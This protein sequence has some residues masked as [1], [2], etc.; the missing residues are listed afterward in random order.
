MER[1]KIDVLTSMRFW[2]MVFI[3]SAHYD[4]LK[5]YPCEKAYEIYR[6]NLVTSADYF[7][8]L[9]GFG[10]VL[11]NRRL[12]NLSPI[13]AVKSAAGRMKKIY[14]LYIGT[15]IICIPW[16][17]YVELINGKSV[18]FAIGS[19]L[20]KLGVDALLLQSATGLQAFSQSFNSVAWFLSSLFLL[21]V[22]SPYL[23]KLNDKIKEQKK[24]IALTMVGNISLM[25]V[26]Y[27]IFYYI[28]ARSFFDTLS[29]VTPYIR[30]FYFVMGILI[31]DLVLLLKDDR[32]I[33]FEN[34]F[35]LFVLTI[36]FLNFCAGGY[37]STTAIERRVIEC[38]LSSLLLYV[39]TFQ[40][41]LVEK[42]FSKPWNV[43]LGEM[44]MYFLFIFG[45]KI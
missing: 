2:M 7:F 24:W 26:V 34:C 1:K 14:P 33:T 18:A 42:M 35:G 44:T 19:V 15:L 8:A 16:Q 13:N 10:L 29:Y 30:V 12:E 25:V 20:A 41:G 3:I 37:L 28:E 43:K 22:I 6:L 36:V 39:C 5:G 4:F 40:G 9:S 27:N 31:A 21:Y 11:S 23:L 17:M 32:N 38:V 45:C